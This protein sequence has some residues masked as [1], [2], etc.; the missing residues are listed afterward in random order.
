MAT[1]GALYEFKN[2]E[3]RVAA[4]DAIGIVMFVSESIGI[5]PDVDING[6]VVKV[7]LQDDLLAIARAYGRQNPV[8]ISIRDRI[9]FYDSDLIIEVSKEGEET[10]YIAIEVSITCGD[11]DTS[12]AIRHAGILTKFTGKQ[13]WPLVTGVRFDERIQPFIDEGKVF[14][15]P[16]ADSDLVPIDD[17]YIK[18]GERHA[19]HRTTL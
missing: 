19:N 5:D 3:E 9:S 12:R 11:R 13:A 6:T 4:K 18:K 8:D 15:Y 17:V 16:T 14:W 1:K 2:Y 10:Y 7:L